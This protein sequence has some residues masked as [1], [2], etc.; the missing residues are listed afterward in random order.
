MAPFFD[1]EDN[2]DIIFDAR[3]LRELIL[4]EVGVL[5]DALEVV[6]LQLLQL[7]EPDHRQEEC[8]PR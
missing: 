3:T 2:N 6:Q 8:L 1:S 5:V 4:D 7:N